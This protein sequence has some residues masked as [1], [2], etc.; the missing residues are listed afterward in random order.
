MEWLDFFPT[1]LY[2]QK[3]RRVK[4]SKADDVDDVLKLLSFFG[5]MKAINKEFFFD[6]E[7]DDEDQI[8]NI[9]W[10]NASCRG[11]Y[12]DFGDCITFDTT[13]RTNQ[14]LMPLG[15]FVGVNHHLQSTIFACTLIREE[16]EKSFQ[17]IFQT[18]LRCMNNKH[19]MVILTGTS[20]TMPNIGEKRSSKPLKK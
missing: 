17:W 8:K 2:L 9:F 13:Y 12:Q 14:Y 1:Y 6:F 19:P 7:L 5:E 4:N 16:T 10:A 3:C 20:I 15:V 11:A 18:F